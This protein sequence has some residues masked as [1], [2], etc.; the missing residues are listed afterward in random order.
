V[1]KFIAIKQM[2]WLGRE[3]SNLR[4]AESKSDYFS[5]KINAHS[6]KI[7]KFDPLSTNRLPEDSE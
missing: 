4:I 6:E 2:S 1:K 3:E 7:A 5:F